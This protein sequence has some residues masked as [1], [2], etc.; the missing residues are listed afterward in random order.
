MADEGLPI[1]RRRI[2]EV[3]LCTASLAARPRISSTARRADAWCAHACAQA[4]LS[5]NPDVFFVLSGT[6]QARFYPGMSWGNGFVVDPATI[7]KYN[8]SDPSGFFEDISAVPTLANRTILS[9]HVYGPNITVRAR[10]SKCN[11]PLNLSERIGT[12]PRASR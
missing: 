7:Q 6:G 11:T 3:V 10:P 8:L 4:I 9:V 12:R 5:I 2:P 1:E